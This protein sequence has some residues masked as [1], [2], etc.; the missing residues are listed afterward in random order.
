MHYKEDRRWDRGK[1]KLAGAREV[2]FFSFLDQLHI[3][4]SRGLGMQK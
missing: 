2:C 4:L 3:Q 1:G